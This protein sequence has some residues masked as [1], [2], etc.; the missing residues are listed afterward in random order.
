MSD[1][2]EVT[3]LTAVRNGMPYLQETVACI[4]AQSFTNWEYIIVDDS[5]DDE[6]ADWIEDEAHRD[7]RII[8]IR[9]KYQGGPF[10]A[11][12]DGLHQARGE[13]IIHIDADDLSPAYR[14]EHQLTYLKSNPQLRACITP[15]QSFNEN[16]LI[17]NSVSQI[18]LRPK[19]LCWYLLLRTFASH[20]SLCIRRDALLELGGYRELPAAQ[21]YRLVT[22]LCKHNWLG[23]MPEIL[24]NV[25]RH[26]RRISRTSGNVQTQMA[27][28][29]MTEYVQDLTGESWTREELEALWFAGHGMLFPIM[30]GIRS[31]CKWEQAWNSDRN[32]TLEERHDLAAF[33]FLHRLKF[34]RANFR[35]QP[36]Q[37]LSVINSMAISKPYW[38]FY[39]P[40]MV[41]S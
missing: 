41:K 13:Y 35:Q 27:L 1:S 15:W 33:S 37:V 24:S 12:N 29:I 18:P 34:L 19:V 17:A 32:L 40:L 8:S 10:A 20:S 6:S 39:K 4:Q 21:D 16:G 23:I 30:R 5:S 26:A 14:I 28:D 2:P 31:I 38:I 36:W 7:P 9:R 22:E 3:V 11:A 25:R